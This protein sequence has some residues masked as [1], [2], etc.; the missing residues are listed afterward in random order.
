[1]QKL[2]IVISQN[3]VLDGSIISDQSSGG[4][5]A[6]TF[7]ICDRLS[8]VHSYLLTLIHLVPHRPIIL[9]PRLPFLADALERDVRLV[10]VH[11]E[12]L[13]VSSRLFVRPAEEDGRVALGGGDVNIIEAVQAKLG[14]AIMQLGLVA[15][16]L[17][18]HV[19]LRVGLLC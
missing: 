10:L 9:R 19:A 8:D 7:D 4:C 2:V 17:E 14:L 12:R 6:H 13:E 5:F 16:D 1:M 11:L 18:Q 3:N 15:V